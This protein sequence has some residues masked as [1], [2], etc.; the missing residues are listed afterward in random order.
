ML[1]PPSQQHCI[2]YLLKYLPLAA[3]HLQQ[4]EITPWASQ[5]LP[6]LLTPA[7]GLKHLILK[8]TKIHES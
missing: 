1:C 5:L 2:S 3:H 6:Q 4:I 7:E 8:C